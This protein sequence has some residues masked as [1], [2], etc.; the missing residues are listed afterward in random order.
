[1]SAAGVIR[2]PRAGRRGASCTCWGASFGKRTRA[3]IVLSGGGCAARGY[4]LVAALHDGEGVDLPR[5]SPE[6]GGALLKKRT[7]R[8]RGWA[9]GQARRRVTGPRR[10]AFRWSAPGERRQH[11]DRLRSPT[12]TKLELERWVV[13]LRAQAL[14]LG[15]PVRCVKAL[16]IRSGQRPSLPP[17]GPVVRLQPHGF[18]EPVGRALALAAPVQCEAKCERGGGGR[19]LR[20]RGSAPTHDLVARQREAAARAALHPVA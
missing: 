15:E 14:D 18:P 1:M 20:R 10:S 19:D 11:R 8:L 13:A 16:A 6:H 5:G 12:P 4:E 17:I 9:A 7:H 3:S 2:A